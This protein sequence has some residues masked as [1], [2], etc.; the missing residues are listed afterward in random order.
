MREHVRRKKK[1]RAFFNVVCMIAQSNLLM[2]VCT[3]ACF[4]SSMLE[5]AIYVS[6][7]EYICIHIYI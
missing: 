5:H 4:V 1:A 2:F 6:I 7:Y 3:D